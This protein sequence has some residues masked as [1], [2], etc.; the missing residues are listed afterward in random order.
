M[1]QKHTKSSFELSLTEVPGIGESRARALFKHF[2]TKK[3]MAA[4]SMDELAAAPQMNRR[5]AAALY[6]YLHAND[7]VQ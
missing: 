5:A 3:A 6:G 4:A 1:K 7:I 2:K